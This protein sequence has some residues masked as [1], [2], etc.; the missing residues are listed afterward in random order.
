[1]AAG[2]PIEAEDVRS[3]AKVALLGQTVVQNLF[4][5]S[6]PVGEII[7]LAN[8][9]FTVIGVLDSKGQSTWGQ[10]Q[11]DTVLIPL[12]TGNRSVFGTNK[13]GPGRIDGI[14]IKIRLG[15][16]MTEAESQIRDLLRQ[17]QRLK[18]DQE[19]TFVVRNL[20]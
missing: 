4:P 12:S 15:E 1:V 14:V 5:Y 10:D 9:P 7:R 8:V 16:D 20:S 3:A 13:S 2:R 19:D 17:R 6:D 11:D 18:H